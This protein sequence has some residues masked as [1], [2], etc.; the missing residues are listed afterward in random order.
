LHIE[1]E[2]KKGSTFSFTLPANPNF[3]VEI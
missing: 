2:E 3:E 1:S